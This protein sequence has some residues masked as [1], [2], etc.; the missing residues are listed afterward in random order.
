MKKHF[1][2]NLICSSSNYELSIRVHKTMYL[3]REEIVHIEL[4]K[5]Q[6]I[7]QVAYILVWDKKTYLHN[8]EDIEKALSIGKTVY[9]E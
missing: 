2:T 7:K 8:E 6:T 9:Y 4:S 5:Y 1:K 3:S